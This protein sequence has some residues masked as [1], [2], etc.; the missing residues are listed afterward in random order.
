[1]VAH[2]EAGG[3]GQC[4]VVLW[5]VRHSSRVGRSGPYRCGPDRRRRDGRGLSRARHEAR[6]RR[7][8]QGAARAT[9]RAIPSGWRGSNAKRACSR[10]STIR[11]SARFTASKRRTASARSCSNWS[12]ARRWPSGSRAGPVP[13]D[14]AL[15]I[16]AADRRCARGG[17]REGHRPP[18]SE[19][20]EHQDHAG[21]RGEGARLR[22]RQGDATRDGPTAELSQSPTMTLGGDARRA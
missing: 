19:A 14:E 8:D 4:A 12:R 16:A 2:R 9:S 18:R 20:G 21:R 6:P 5:R 10:R 13:L 3:F 11:T 7:R 15:A 22:A 17:A 1:M